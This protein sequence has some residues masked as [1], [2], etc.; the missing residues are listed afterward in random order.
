MKGKYPVLPDKKTG[1]EDAALREGQTQR[2][3]QIQGRDPV[4]GWECLDFEATRRLSTK[5]RKDFQPSRWCRLTPKVPTTRRY[6]KPWLSRWRQGQKYNVLGF[7]I[8]MQCRRTRGPVGS[9]LVAYFGGPDWRASPELEVGK[10]AGICENRGPAMQHR[11]QCVVHA[12]CGARGTCE[13]WR[14]G[15][16]LRSL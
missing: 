15:R 13:A 4:L 14:R 12:W 1:S 7:A 16:R 11:R 5:E 3:K 8:S 2:G 6:S 10:R 9:P